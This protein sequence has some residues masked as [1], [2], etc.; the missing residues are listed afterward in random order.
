MPARV[1]YGRMCHKSHNFAAPL[2]YFH[3]PAISG[4]ENRFAQSIARDCIS[5]DAAFTVWNVDMKALKIASAATAAL[6]AAVAA[7]L[8]IGI[9]SGFVTS[10]IQARLERETGYRVV[11][12]GATRLGV[13]PSPSL[14]VH[15]VTLGDPKDRDV[16][17]RLSVERIQA[18]I[19]WQS[20]L[21]GD[22]QISELTISRP[23]LHVPL[24]RERSRRLG[25]P[26]K[27]A[28]VSG[29][30]R[31][32]TFPVGHLTISDG[33]VVFSNPRDRVENRIDGI[34]ADAR[35]GADR[36]IDVAGSA[37]LG[38]HPLQFKIKATAPAVLGDR[39]TVPVDLNLDAPGLLRP[40]LTGKAEVRLS[41]SVLMINGLTG[42][43]GDGQFNGWASADLASK[44][45]V[46]VDLDFQRL[47]VGTPSRGLSGATDPRPADQP[48]SAEKIDLSGLNYVDAQI[49]ISAAELIIGD[50]RIAPAAADA[51]L[52]GGVLKAAFS[53]LGVYGG[54]A[55]GELGVDV[56]TSNTAYTL[57]CDLTGVRALPLLSG[58]AD[59]DKLDGKMQAKISFRGA[60]DSQ[61]A[62]L[63]SLDGSA[64]V[65]F[66]DGAIRGINVA[67]MIR[68][69]TS[70]TLSGW[71]EGKDQTTDL[72][73][74]GASFRIERGQATTGDLLLF[75]PLVRMNGAGTVDLVAKSL[76]F[77]VE[78]KLVMTLEGQGGAADPVGLGIPVAVQGPWSGPAIY[79]D[80][81]GILSD[82]DAAYAKLREMGKGLFGSGGGA[83]DPLSGKLGDTLGALI[84]QGLGAAATRAPAAS[85]DTQVKP[86]APDQQSPMNDILK[87][88]FGR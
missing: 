12:A 26:A 74:L 51:A 1:A 87:Q 37:R 60:G 43:L 39:Q 79:P 32:K 68:S 24:L 61:R 6:I 86:A 40:P 15:D 18:D 77:R 33:T 80:I 29:D 82:P 35:A 59:F 78:P 2:D 22:L 71:Q 84:Q 75:G 45:L 67:K 53:H 28:T 63:S 65:N 3:G 25:N 20:L 14:T 9:P 64:F 10:A 16:S 56:T 70:G 85:P 21:S 4:F 55:D 30:T 41:G 42:T 66:Q 36:R 52:S 83:S 7:V 13:L 44:P 88:L 38:E 23:V 19:P 8:M 27:P 47:D 49:R 73:Q 17:D 72:T 58:L 5:R 69:L 34:N 11:I 62:I 46:K 57:R 48:W 54:E 31:A 50:A 81:A 76:A